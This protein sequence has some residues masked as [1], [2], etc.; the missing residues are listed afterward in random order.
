VI[1]HHRN[2]GYSP[3][4]ING[5]YVTNAAGSGHGCYEL[6]EISALQFSWQRSS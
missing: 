3:Q 4:A 2:N 5:R 1:Q 6:I